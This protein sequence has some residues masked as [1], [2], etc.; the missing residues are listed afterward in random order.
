MTRALNLILRLLPLISIYFS[1]RAG[2]S[3]AAA[4]AVEGQKQELEVTN[5]ILAARTDADGTVAGAVD[6]LRSGK[7]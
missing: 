3:E 1:Y 5:A 4:V 7:F 6:E 2:S